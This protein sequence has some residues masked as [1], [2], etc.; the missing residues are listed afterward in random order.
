MLGKCIKNEFV[1]RTKQALGIILGI[2]GM[3]LLTRLIDVISDSILKSTFMDVFAGFTKALYVIVIIAC[4]VMT[5]FLPFLDFRQ[6]FYKDQGYLTHTLPVK[7]STMLVARM[8]CDIVITV[9]ISLVWILSLCIAFDDINLYRDLVRL[10]TGFFEFT[11]GNSAT[12][13]T[14]IVG[15]L[16]LFMIGTCFST[17]NTIWTT[18]AAYSFGHAFNKNK[19]VMSIVGLAGLV[20]IEMIFVSCV[21]Y[22]VTQA[23][24]VWDIEADINSFSDLTTNNLKSIFF[25]FLFMDIVAFVNVFAMGALTN[26]ICKRHLNVE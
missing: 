17:L 26:Y 4:L 16:I 9:A 21:M 22:V 24:L 13:N 14:L 3:A 5:A 11:S 20:T 19:K 12:Y 15:I 23:G 8:I 25:M 10:I 7:V 2:V 18:N 1:N 6:R